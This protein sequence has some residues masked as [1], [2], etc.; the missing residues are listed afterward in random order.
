MLSEEN[1]YKYRSMLDSSRGRAKLSIA[2]IFFE[3]LSPTL[4]RKMEFDKSLLFLETLLLLLLLLLLFLET[5][6]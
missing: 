3:F 1:L 5:L 6:D 2:F 4:D